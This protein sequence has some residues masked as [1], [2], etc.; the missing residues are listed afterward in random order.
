MQCKKTEITSVQSHLNEKRYISHRDV[1]ASTAMQMSDRH[2]VMSHQL[3]NTS[4]WHTMKVEERVFE[5]RILKRV[6]SLV[7]CQMQYLVR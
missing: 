6:C 1:A 2:S 3:I 4:L 7:S 5:H